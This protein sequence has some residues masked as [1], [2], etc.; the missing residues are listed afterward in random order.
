[1]NRIIPVLLL[2]GKGVIKTKRFSA[3]TYIGDPIN[4]VRIFNEKEVDEIIIL[5]IE[6][7]P[8]GRD[9][10]YG[11]IQEIVSEAFMPV[12]YGGGINSVEQA[13]ALIR[14]GVEKV[15]LNTSALI[16]PK[17]ICDLA[18]ELGSQSVVGSID[19]KKSLF[20]KYQVVTRCGSQKQRVDLI[21]YAK[22]LE[23]A[24]VGE[25]MIGSIDRDGTQSGYDLQLVKSV[26]DAVS[27][28]TIAVGGA[29]ELADFSEVINLAGASAAAAGSAF[30]Y[31]GKFNAVLIN[32]P[33][34]A[35]LQS[36]ISNR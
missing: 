25:I 11:L 4:A 26:S 28:P 33:S 9:P 17:L 2:A 27:V 31:Y 32:Y 3:R 20:S 14:S 30:V 18:Y 13:S 34:Q 22:N 29:K 24:G 5:D 15:S 19:V 1:M 21:E 7:T 36:A 8:Q 16:N 35:E 6:A 12:C 10:E 23:S